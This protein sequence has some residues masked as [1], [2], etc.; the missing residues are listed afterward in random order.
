MPKSSIAPIRQPRL[1]PPNTVTEHPKAATSGHVKSGHLRGSA[2]LAEQRSTSV[3]EEFGHEQRLVAVDAHAADAQGV[4]EQVALG[5]ATDADETFAA[6]GAL[7]HGVRVSVSR[8]RLR[9]RSG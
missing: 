5:A 3:L 1:L 4:H 8:G 9:I 7:V 2:D 6:A